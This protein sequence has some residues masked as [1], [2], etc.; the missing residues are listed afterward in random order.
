VRSE[1]RIIILQILKKETIGKLAAHP[2][3]L[4]FIEQGASLWY[5]RCA[6]RQRRY[7]T[8]LSRM[9]PPQNNTGD[10]FAHLKKSL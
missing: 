9:V 2:V 3:T 8:F 7:N 4:C 5:E 10:Q 1:N 6:S